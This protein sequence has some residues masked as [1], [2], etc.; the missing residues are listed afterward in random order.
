M[1]DLHMH[2]LLSDGVLVPAEL[3]RR[4]E[5]IGCRFI[6]ITDHVDQSN[7]G[8]VVESIVRFA[9][10][11]DHDVK[12]IPGVEVTHVSPGKIA[13]VVNRARAGGARIVLVHGET[14]VEPVKKGTNDAAIDAGADIIAHPGLITLEL[15]KK[16]ASAGV[17]LEISGR[18]GHDLSN[19]HVA[20]MA[21][22]AGATLVFNTDSHAPG[23]LMDR[24]MA[25][26]VVRGAGLNE[27][28]AEAVL[29]YSQTLVEAFIGTV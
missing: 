12:V 3:A 25:L 14:I 19:G 9:D 23:D 28:E 4:S 2:S 26:K 11:N 15:A 7:V 6:A 10:D 13:D 1:I 24:E 21:M 20:R 8:Y 5:E 27:Q 18:K 29:A 16:A 22:E 17:A